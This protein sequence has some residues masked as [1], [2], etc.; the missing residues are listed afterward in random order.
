MWGFN[1]DHVMVPGLQRQYRWGKR[2]VKSQSRLSMRLPKT[3][4]GIWCIR[5][6]PSRVAKPRLQ[7]CVNS[8]LKDVQEVNQGRGSQE[9]FMQKTNK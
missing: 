3:R 9:C 6:A 7:A 2:E 8:R 1:S 4:M 5:R